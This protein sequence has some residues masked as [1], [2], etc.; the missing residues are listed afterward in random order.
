M[1]LSSGKTIAKNTSYLYFRMFFTML[2]S[3]YTVRAVLNILGV[4]DYGIYNAVGGVVTSLSFLTGVLANASNRFFAIELGKGKD[5]QLENC[6]NAM[7]AAYLGIAVLIFLVIEIG[8]VWMLNNVL[9]IPPGELSTATIVMHFSLAAFLLTIIAN[10]FQALLIAKEEMR[11]YA[12]INLFESFAKLAVVY[13]LYKSPFDKLSYY[14]FLLFSVTLIVQLSY[15]FFSRRKAPI[16]LSLKIDVSIIKTIFGYSSW[17]L[18]GTLTGVASIQ[19]VS[20][21]LNVFIGPIANAAFA[22]ATQISNTLQTFASSFYT[23]VRPPLIKSYAAKDYSY[24]NSLFSFSNKILF[25]L[26]F[27][28]VFPLCIKTD[29][30][31]KLWLGNVSEYMI[32]SVRLML[33][34]AMM[35]CLSYPI[36]TVV[37]AAGKVKLYHGLVD[38]LTLISL[39]VAYVIFKLKLVVDAIV[40]MYVLVLFFAHFIRLWVM[41]KVV[42]FDYKQYVQF[43]L[44]PASIITIISY[45]T[46]NIIKQFFS[47]SLLGEICHVCVLVLIPLILSLFI[48]FSRQDRQK[49]ME[50]FR[51]NKR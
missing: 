35:I 40:V 8:G 9:T 2:V 29:F 22:I 18:I 15:V 48:L 31:L 27:I 44:I 51:K 23:A 39:P 6:F 42:E 26:T 3:L 32:L 11:V 45:L 28:M 34:Y 38:G 10:P 21:F 7:F 41:Y 49:I 17:T 30:V 47:S 50:L 16:K 24:M 36:T 12:Y 20:I 19:G 25:I 33:L 46:N 4:E 14:A 13:L 1:Q 43:L 5:G 37:Q